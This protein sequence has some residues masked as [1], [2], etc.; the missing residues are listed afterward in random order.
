MPCSVRT[1]GAAPAATC[2]AVRGAVVVRFDKPTPRRYRHGMPKLLLINPSY[3]RT[4]G[5]NQAGIA[6]PVYPILGL[7]VLGGAARAAG[8]QVKLLDLS[9][10][11]YDPALVRESIRSSEEYRHLPRR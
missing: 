1:P 5:A 11:A 9:Y 7:A 4:Y 10:R 3:A 8:H 2:A 6:N